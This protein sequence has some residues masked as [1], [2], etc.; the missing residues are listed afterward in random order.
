MTFMKFV[1]NGTLDPSPSQ[2][3]HDMARIRREC[4]RDKMKHLSDDCTN[5]T[6][7]VRDL[8]QSGEDVTVELAELEAAAS[9]LLLV[10]QLM[11][12]EPV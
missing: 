8:K 1:T 7:F 5:A 9:A 6:A 2:R 3:R 10:V 12:R 11:R 4:F